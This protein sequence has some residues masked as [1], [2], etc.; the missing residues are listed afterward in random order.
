MTRVE[1]GADII[2]AVHRA[3]KVGTSGEVEAGQPVF[4]VRVGK[5]G[6]IEE[7]SLCTVYKATSDG[8]GV[9]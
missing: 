5:E 7:G 3:Y 4:T 2:L 8:L 6:V 9:L 1:K